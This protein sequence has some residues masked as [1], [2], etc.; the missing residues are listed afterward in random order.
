MVLN[1]QTKLLLSQKNKLN[2]KKYLKQRNVTAFKSKVEITFLVLTLYFY[3]ISLNDK[4]V[5]SEIERE[6]I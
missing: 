4:Q 3:D 2:K 5:E 1:Q 6:E